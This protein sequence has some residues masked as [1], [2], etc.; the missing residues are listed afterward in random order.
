C[1]GL[2]RERL[3]QSALAPRDLRAIML[4]G[5]P[6]RTPYLRRRLSEEFG[7]PLMHDRDPMTVVAMGAAIHAS[8]LLIAE[9]GHVSAA[10]RPSDATL[11]LHYDSVVQEPAVTV[12]GRIVSPSGFLGEVR[13]QSVARDTDTGWI[14]LRN[15]AFVADMTVSETGATEFDISLRDALG[16]LWGVRPSSFAVRCGVIPAQGV[17][18]YRY[19]VVLQNDEVEWILREGLPLPAYGRAHTLRL[20]RTLGPGSDERAAVY[21][22][23]GLSDVATDNIKVGE[24]WIQGSDLSRPL[25]EG[26]EVEVRIRMDESR[27]L[28]AKVSVP[29]HDL[30]WA[31]DFPTKLYSAPIT[32][33]RQSL[34]EAQEALARVRAEV[35]DD[36]ER[37]FVQAQSDLDRVEADMDGMTS[38]DIE[39]ATRV[40]KKLADA[41][42]RIR[43]L[44]RT[45][46]LQAR[47]RDVIATIARAEEV[48]E[49][50]G[51]TVG[52]ASA[53]EMRAQADRARELADLQGLM[54]VEKRADRLFWEHYVKTAECWAGLVEHL[55]DRRSEASDPGAY[56]TFLSRAEDALARDD[57]EGVRI[58]GVQAMRLLP[59]ESARENR[60][61]ASLLRRA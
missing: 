55:Q 53:D 58:N 42:P 33:L 6:T 24:L 3:A 39:G 57:H 41:K 21:F 28:T 23:E 30:E 32:D 5:G 51:D 38:S 16:T 35:V 48:A 34:Q 26:D 47:H 40:A 17:T 15:G 4:V 43:S 2:I 45:Y 56:H 52:A 25:R 49:R 18:P 29:L 13:I 14:P 44:V 1:V 61:W 31:V 9:V 19:G 50:F 59:E 22:V 37:R 60:F 36:D 46:D 20:A 10:T 27:R 7:V 8:T 54:A 11:E 12:S